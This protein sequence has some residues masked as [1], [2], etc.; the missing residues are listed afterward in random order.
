MQRLVNYYPPLSW[1]QVWSIGPPEGGGVRTRGIF[2]FQFFWNL[3]ARLE[4]QNWQPHAS[5]CWTETPNGFISPTFWAINHFLT[6]RLLT[7]SPKFWS[8]NHT[9]KSENDLPNFQ[10]RDPQTRERRV[11]R[12]S[13]AQNTR[14]TNPLGALI[15]H[16]QSPGKIPEP[17][18]TAGINFKKIYL[19]GMVFPK[20]SVEPGFF[21]MLLAYV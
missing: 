9:L 21:D 5:M 14:E 17:R 3:D 8:K 20:S 7:C 15:K 10:K 19:D 16:L 1:P 2:F 11:R 6:H 4:S 13:R 18:Q 12:W